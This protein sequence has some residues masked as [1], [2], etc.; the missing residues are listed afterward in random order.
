MIRSSD[1]NCIERKRER[2]WEKEKEGG[3]YIQGK[4]T[5]MMPKEIWRQNK[6][7]VEG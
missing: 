3:P 6:W 5:S 2:E 4:E 7:K 1:L